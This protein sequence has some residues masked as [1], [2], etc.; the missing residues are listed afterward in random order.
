MLKRYRAKGK[1]CYKETNCSCQ[2]MCST[3]DDCYNHLTKKEQIE[4]SDNQDGH[5][6]LRK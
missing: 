4:W 5:N 6:E 3:R 1:A 2:C